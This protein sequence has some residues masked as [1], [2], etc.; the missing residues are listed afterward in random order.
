MKQLEDLGIF[1]AASLRDREFPDVSF[2]V[3]GVF[4]EGVTILA[5]KPKIGKSWLALDIALAV[6][7][8]NA[9]C[10]GRSTVHGDAL[11]CALEDNKRRLKR[12]I[13]LCGGQWP[14]RL[15]LATEWPRLDDG[16]MTRIKQWAQSVP[17]PKLI[18]LDTLAKVR[19]EGTRNGQYAEDYE[20]LEKLHHWAGENGIAVLVLH[21][22][23]KMDAEDPFDT[24][25][26]TL[27]LTG[28]ADTIAVFHRSGGGVTLHV[29]GRDVEEAAHA[30]MFDK[31]VCR[32][33]ILGDAVEVRRSDIRNR[34]L[35]VLKD[36]EDPLGPTEVARRLGEKPATIKQRLFQMYNAGEVE[37]DKGGH[38]RHPGG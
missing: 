11:Y 36:A 29:R 18:I 23:R 4:P 25:S 37:K 22:T 14:E 8:P 10:L 21:H 7:S 35:E 27:G 26:G 30:M 16:G 38:Y 12:R 13:K 3:D 31:A 17:E 20:A 9:N 5:G 28:C 33:G 15:S 19:G 24:V 2:I 32:W 6:A 34:I 1:S